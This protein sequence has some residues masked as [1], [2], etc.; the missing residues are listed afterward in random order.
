MLFA[1]GLRYEIAS[2]VRYQSGQFCVL[3]LGFDRISGKWSIYKFPVR[4]LRHKIAPDI[5]SRC[6]ANIVDFEPGPIINKELSSFIFN[7][8]PKKIVNCRSLS[9][10]HEVFC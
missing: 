1:T 5:R 8:F 9:P 4:N 6:P 2:D 3:I 10:F 7:S